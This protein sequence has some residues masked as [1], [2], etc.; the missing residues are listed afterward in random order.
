[1]KAIFAHRA[2]K[3][4]CSALVIVVVVVADAPS[5]VTT[6]TFDTFSNQVRAFVMLSPRTAVASRREVLRCGPLLYRNCNSGGSCRIR[7]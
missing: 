5:V 6:L 4:P 7:T 2:D 1:M 3:N